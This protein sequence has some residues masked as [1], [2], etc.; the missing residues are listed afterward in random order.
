MT[1]R[2]DEEGAAIARV[3]LRLH[4]LSKT[5]PGQRALDDVDLE[6]AAGEI[7]AL[8][9]QNGSG[10][11][12]V[13][14][15]LAGYHQPDGGAV[16]EVADVPFELGSAIAASA[17][18]LRFVHQ[19]LG[20]V[21]SMTVSDNFRMNRKL[22]PLVPLRR[23]DDR[24]AAQR[25]LV[26]LGYDIDPGATI[27]Q[28]AESER[29]AVAVAR[30][31]DGATTVGGF[32]LLVLDEATASLP[33]PE[34]ERLFGAL[35]RVAESGTA[36]LFISHYLDEVLTISDRVTV[37]RDGRRVTTEDSARLTHERL[38]HLM[39]G[40]E[41]VA[42]AAAH[43][44]VELP[45]ADSEPVLS[46]RAVGGSD[47]AP[48]SFDVHPGEVVG[49]AGLTGS[50]R[51]ELASLLA[52]RIPRTGDVFV[53]GRRIPA[54]DPRRAID[55]G[56]CY[57]PADRARDAMFRMDSVRENL[58]ISD[59]TPFWSRGRISAKAENEHAQHWI[60]KLDV[61]PARTDAVISE[62]SGGNQ[63]R[64][65]MARWF[66]C[67][68]RVLVL[69]EPTQGVDV[70]SKAD[71]HRLVDLAT[72]QGTATVVCSSD[73]AELARLCSRVVVL[74]RGV[75]IAELR[76]AEIND[77]RIEELQLVPL[78]AADVVI[79]EAERRVERADPE[80]AVA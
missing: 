69:D 39:L 70:G 15:I 64:V 11:S 32:P 13:V 56:L 6:I 77:E 9:G 47:L 66:R 58:T 50:G 79:A 19:D 76:G 4:G 33:G 12:T 43:T 7:H 17:A 78:A 37:L 55:A 24:A 20:L 68:P 22:S 16:A 41:L 5:F 21:E 28:L 36:I 65:V 31:L 46:V 2:G 61:R 75:V 10:K 23:R 59:L 30:A 38:A 27:A 74:Q 49:V 60:E 45:P 44:R 53:G 52:G 8:V 14:K 42:E 48:F 26:A 1:A 72:A 29:T 54:V 62:L 40:R 25:A 35:R 80:G 73:N 18:G 63:Q 34:V 71:I 57:V 67:S 3:A 51:D